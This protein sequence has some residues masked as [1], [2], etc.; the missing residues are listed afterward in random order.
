MYVLLYYIYTPDYSRWKSFLVFADQSVTEKLL[1][2]N[3]NNDPDYHTAANVFQRITVYFY[4]CET[5]PSQ[6]IYNMLYSTLCMLLS[7]THVFLKLITVVG[8]DA[9]Q[10]WPSVFTQQTATIKCKPEVKLIYRSITKFVVSK[11]YY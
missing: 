1:Q 2:W 8:D 4:N 7:C 6:T 9:I 3:S 5:F 10:W 11:W